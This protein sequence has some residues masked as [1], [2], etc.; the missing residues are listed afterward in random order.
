MLFIPGLSAFGHA[1]AARVKLAPP[2]YF[3]L[4]SERGFFRQGILSQNHQPLVWWGDEGDCKV[5]LNRDLATFC[6]FIFNIYII[7]NYC[8]IRDFPFNFVESGAQTK[9]KP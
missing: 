6:F 2:I 7:D 8:K 9:K 1:L 3:P 5:P 4:D